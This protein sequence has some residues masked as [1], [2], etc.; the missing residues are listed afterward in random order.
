MTI[1]EFA[2]QKG[3]ST[4]AVYSKLKANDISIDSLTGAEYGVLSS[5]GEQVLNRLYNTES[6]KTKVKRQSDSE[7]IESCLK[8]IEDLQNR[9]DLLTESI[10]GKDALID[11][12]QKTLEVE[13]Q[14][15]SAMMQLLLPASAGQGQTS[16]FGK[17][18]H[19][20]W[21]SLKGK[22]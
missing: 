12:L 19:S 18:V 1:K 6:A 3:I 2:K 4:Q 20:V 7:R 16:S 11:T 14:S 13:R 22:K 15:H 21:Q 10:R 8:Q 5:E 17:K 9:V